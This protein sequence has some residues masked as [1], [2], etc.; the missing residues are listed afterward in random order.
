MYQTKTFSSEIKGV[1]VQNRLIEGYFSVFDFEDSDG[2]IITRGAFAKTIRENGPEGKN[3]IMHL[4]QHNPTKPLGK[5]V[6]L[7]EDGYG[8]KFMT[9][10]TETSYGMDTL[11]LYEDGVLKEHSIGFNTIKSGPN[12]QG[13][14]E[15]T[16]VKL[17]EGS[18]VTWGANELA[19]VKSTE[20]LSKKELLE[21]YNNLCKAY[22]SGDYTDGTFRIIEQQKN[23]IE[24]LI[25]LD[26]PSNDTQKQAA[27]IGRLFDEFNRQEQLK[28]IFK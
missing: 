13:I 16:E 4:L 20:D 17:W 9:K 5:P 10:I 12:S 1:D 8:L 3:R 11:K 14:N 22:Y 19:L 15:I 18:T 26:E 24:S 6:E 21:K 25:A 27:D 7:M 28:Q 2:D 23:Y